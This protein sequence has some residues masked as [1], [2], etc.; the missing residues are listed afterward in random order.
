MPQVF[1]RGGGAGEDE[2]G[3]AG[4]QLEHV[5][6]LHPAQGQHQQRQQIHHVGDGQESEDANAEKD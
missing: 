4:G 5:L 3:G 2:G 1:P 6:P